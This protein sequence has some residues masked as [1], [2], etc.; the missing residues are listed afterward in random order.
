MLARIEAFGLSAADDPFGFESRLADDQ[1]WTLGHALAVTEQYRRFLVLTQV[2]GQAVSPS[3]DVDEAWHLHLTRTT[4]YEA[5]C[6]AVFGKFL[7]HEPARS[8][9]GAKHRNLYAE[10]LQAYRRAF[11]VDAPDAIWPE[12]ARRL[13]TPPPAADWPLPAA[14]RGGSKLA[15]AG[16][17]AAFVVAV[18]LFNVG[19][20][21]PLQSIG[22]L[23]FL[24]FELLATLAIG[25]VG[26]RRPAPADVPVERDVLEPYEVAW[27]SGGAERMTMTAVVAL[28]D[29]GVLLAPGKPP[30]KVPRPPIPVNAT[31]ERRVEH[32]AE[33]A[34]LSVIADGGV[35][36][37]AAC[38]AM[39]PLA[40]QFERRLVAAGI[41]H[42]TGAMPL[43]SAR[44][45][46][47]LLALLAV[48]LER[49]FHALAGFHRFGFLVLFVLAHVVLVFALARPQV[50]TGARAERLLR[51]LRLAAGRYK[52]A[53]PVGQALAFGVALVGASVLAN[54]LRFDGLQQQIGAAALARRAAG[55]GRDDGPDCSSCS[56]CSTSSSDGGSGGSDGGSSSCSG[57]S[58]CSSSCGGGG[59]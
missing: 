42:V 29:R 31:V 21:A 3:P 52:T 19:L 23:P 28:T 13:G 11:H 40:D 43:R 58:S 5:F 18:V 22:P 6:N 8:G 41:A 27:L 10:T 1:G 36:Y 7:H 24:A 25:G 51:P 34:C 45:L 55:G 35:R 33:R 4:H 44:A 57:G 48:E 12:D 37:A 38:R 59:D 32:P 2:A 15:F 56:S 47:V 30:A 14:L 50:R 53:P 16:L 46:L 9:E 17:V 39:Q 26:L 20:L 54:D 49:L